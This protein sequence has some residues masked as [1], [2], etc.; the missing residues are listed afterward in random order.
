LVVHR[1]E[2]EQLPELLP[3]GSVDR[4]VHVDGLP[5]LR[6]LSLR[7]VVTSGEADTRSSHTIRALPWA[8]LAIA[9]LLVVIWQWCR[10][11]RERADAAD[12]EAAG[13]EPE[14][15]LVG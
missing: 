2:A 1:G 15:Q 11:R 12:S 5:P 9:V 4:S 7:V 14:K 3:G 8:W 10:R 6:R 13:P